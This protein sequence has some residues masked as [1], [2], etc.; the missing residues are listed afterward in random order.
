MTTVQELIDRL[1]DF[2]PDMEI[3]VAYQPSYPLTGYLAAVTGP[4]DIAAEEPCDEHGHY[5]CDECA[6]DAPKIVWLAVG[7]GDV[8]GSPYAPRAAWEGS[9]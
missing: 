4:E 2:D 7:Q 1:G 8:N 5:N 6:E 9:I 3:G